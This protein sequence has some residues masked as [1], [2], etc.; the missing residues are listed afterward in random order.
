MKIKLILLTIAILTLGTGIASA[1]TL[2]PGYGTLAGTQIED[3][4][5]D[6][7]LESDTEF[8][9]NQAGERI[10]NPNYGKI[11]VGDVLVA[12]IQATQ[13]VDILPPYSLSSPD[14]LSGPADELVALAIVQ[15]INPLPNDPAGRIR[16]GQLSDLPMV[17]FYSGSSE[18]DFNPFT[19][20]DINSMIASIVDGD[21]L[22]AFSITSDPDTE[23]FFDPI[24]AGAD[25]PNVVRLLPTYNKVGALN[26]ALNQ[27]AGDDIFASLQLACGLFQC[28]GDGLADISGSA[29]ILGGGGRVNA[30]ATSD[31]DMAVNPVPEPSTLVLLGLGLLS[32]GI[33]RYRKR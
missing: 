19:D 21:F 13:N 10:P 5:L 20:P 8:I 4:D 25:D 26:F 23:W 11:T 2:W 27:V 3:D 16:F 24:I 18:T 29:D 7:F 32:A 15:V 31:A 30:F 6:Y 12:G 17:Q 28:T 1:F 33:V 14:L 9:I 22:W